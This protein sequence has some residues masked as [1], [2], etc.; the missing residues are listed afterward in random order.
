VVGR[1]RGA[2]EADNDRERT[3]IGGA[4][5]RD[6]V[7]N[8]P[9]D[10][11]CGVGGAIGLTVGVGI[12][13]ALLWVVGAL[14]WATGITTALSVVGVSLLSVLVG[15]LR[16]PMTAAGKQHA[17]PTVTDD[18]ID[19]LRVTIPS[20]G[21]RRML[22]MYA[23]AAGV[24]PFLLLGMIQKGAAPGIG[25]DVTAVLLGSMIALVPLLVAGTIAIYLWQ[26]AA[27]DVVQLDD[28]VLTLRR[29]LGPWS[30]SR[31]FDLA[32]VRDVRHDPLVPSPFR[33]YHPRDLG[34]GG[35]IA[36][37]AGGKTHRFGLDLSEADAQNLIALIRPRC[38]GGSK[39]H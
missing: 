39:E 24:W 36:F 4:M 20:V 28:N 10:G 31:T 32:E 14:D 35:V 34:I 11:K 38:K 30:V 7:R 19:G 26:Y 13:L 3:G 27:R 21:D 8:H 23:M 9:A 6:K 12:A 37:D 25:S 15:Q 17:R 22:V 5:T 2:A 18:E 16:W 33:T 1:L 29:E